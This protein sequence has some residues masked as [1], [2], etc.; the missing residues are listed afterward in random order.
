MTSEETID[1]ERLRIRKGEEF[2]QQANS[3]G[4]EIWKR[5][6]DI[7]QNVNRL[8]RNWGLETASRGGDGSICKA[9]ILDN[10]SI[11]SGVCTASSSFVDATLNWRET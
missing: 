1:M 3:C 9:V 6:T 7:A 8:K 4:A 11:D 2:A 5:S 10:Q